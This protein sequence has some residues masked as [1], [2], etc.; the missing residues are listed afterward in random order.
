MVAS[1]KYAAC[2]RTIAEALKTASEQFE[3]LAALHEETITLDTGAFV[4]HIAGE[5]Q[6]E[7]QRITASQE[8]RQANGDNPRE[9]EELSHKTD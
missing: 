6:E 4:G 5:M 8:I 3:T 7:L 9:D 1:N 2:Y